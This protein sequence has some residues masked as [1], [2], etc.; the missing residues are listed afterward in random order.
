MPKVVTSKQEIIEQSRKVFLENG[1][2]ATS[3]SMLSKACNIQKAHF[4]YYFEN[5]EAL[6][7]AVLKATRNLFQI[8]VY[9][10]AIEKDIRSHEILEE[11][12][13]EFETMYLDLGGCI[14]GNTIL[15]TGN[16]QTFK[17]ELRGFMDDLKE[18]LTELY[19]LKYNYEMET[20]KAKA[21]QVIQDVQGGIILMKLYGEETHLN[22]AIERAKS[23]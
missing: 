21:A 11:L 22:Q 6:M 10:K 17:A 13:Y 2:H 15:E 12:L 19:Y 14:I 23:L 3:I 18:V 4:Y 8:Y 9:D 5:K 16:Q 7:K 20:A 1:Y